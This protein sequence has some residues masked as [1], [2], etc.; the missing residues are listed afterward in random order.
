M[1]RKIVTKQ[2]AR[3]SGKRHRGLTHLCFLQLDRE[4]EKRNSR[5]AWLLSLGA[6]GLMSHVQ[7]ATEKLDKTKRGTPTRVAATYCPFCG[8]K[9]TS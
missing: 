2:E 9:L 1:K 4:L 3:A 6:D 5:I 7:I 8:K